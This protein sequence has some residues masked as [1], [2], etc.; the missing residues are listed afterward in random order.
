MPEKPSTLESTGVLRELQEI[1]RLLILGLLR[2]GASQKHVAKALGV[3]QSSIS[4][5]FPEKIGKSKKQSLAKSKLI[6]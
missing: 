3:N 4:R 5:M 2:T 6:R 1:K